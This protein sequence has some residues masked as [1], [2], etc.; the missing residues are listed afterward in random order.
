MS[1]VPI[2]RTFMTWSAALL[3]AALAW[4]AAPAAAR[5][6][7]ADN[8]ITAPAAD[9]VLQGTVDVMGVATH[10]AFRKWQLDIL[11]NGD[12]EQAHFL[13]VSESQATEP[14]LLMPL[15]TRLFPDGRHLLRLRVVHSNLNY[16]EY[17]TPIA[18]AN[19]GE[20]PPEMTDGTEEMV[21]EIAAVEG[22]QEMADAAG[23]LLIDPALPLPAA[24]PAG[25]PTE[26]RWVEVDLSDQ[27]VTA[28]DGDQVFMHTLVSTGKASTPT[29]T[30]RFKV[31]V[32]L[33]ETRMTG[34][35]YDTPDVPWTMYYYRGYALHGAYWHNNFGTPVS[36]G[37]VNLP[38]DKAQALFEWADVGME[39]IVHE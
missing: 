36:H 4:L 32:K 25:S 34:P 29:V 5:A 28:W 15:D 1:F 7:A 22:V 38:V 30:G 37:C 2:Q 31:R 33:P 17:F 39:V 21:E 11:T 12:P 27:T 8:G 3:V 13:A 18:I 9:A 35:D 10:P 26:G 24:P 16:I 23:P 19:G 14:G 20:L 6:E